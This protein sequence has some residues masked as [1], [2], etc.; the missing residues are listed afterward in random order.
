MKEKL[1]VEI[2]NAM[3]E[4]LNVEQMALLNG[5][6]L[7]VVSKYNITADEETKQATD[8]TNESLLHSFLSAKQVEG[9]SGPT[10]RYYGNTIQQLYKKIGVHSLQELMQP[11]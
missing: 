4:A 11:S 9:C 2:S 10:V 5:V 8:E 1:I 6:L 3:A 7:R